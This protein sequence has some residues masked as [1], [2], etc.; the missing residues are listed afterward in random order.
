MIIGACISAP[1]TSVRLGWFRSCALSTALSLNQLFFFFPTEKFFTAVTL[2]RR[3][4]HWF[5]FQSELCNL[6]MCEQERWN[7][8]HVF[9][10][11]KKKK[12]IYLLFTIG[13]N[14]TTKLG[15]VRFAFVISSMALSCFSWFCTFSI[16]L[17]ATSKSMTNQGDCNLVRDIVHTL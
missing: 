5:S 1:G 9:P 12:C 3:S 17:K 13:N 4:A 15:M 16:F 2:I 14:Q 8:K 10:F 11:G 6:L 7:T